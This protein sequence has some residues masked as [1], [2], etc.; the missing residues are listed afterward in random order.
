MRITEGRPTDILVA[1]YQTTQSA[2]LNCAS[3]DA[4]LV[5]F[6]HGF[7]GNKDEKGLFVEADH[8]FISHG[9]STLRFDF[10][11]CGD[12]E[13]SFSAVRFSDLEIDLHSVLKFVKKDLD[14]TPKAIGL[15]GFSLGATIAI[16][17]NSKIV[18]AYAF[19]SPAIFTD[20][21]MYPRYDTYEVRREIEQ[22]GFFLKSGIEVGP[23]FLHDLKQ[24][25]VREKTKLISK[26]VLMLHGENDSRISASNTKKAC[27]L[28]GRRPR[29]CIIPG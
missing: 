1:G 28:F 16:L 19:W 22:N 9:L 2:K 4:P 17:A 26:A 24:N 14:F 13:G 23:D 29:L 8:Y 7:A 27:S 21:D 20:V 18:D 11:G 6:A 10:R 5:V 15:V 12:N 3:Q 25:T